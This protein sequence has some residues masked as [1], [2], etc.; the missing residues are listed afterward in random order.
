[1]DSTTDDWRPIP[2]YGGDYAISRAGGVRSNVFRPPIRVGEPLQQRSGYRG[3]W[4]VSLWNSATR[5]QK[6][7][8]VH[9]LMASIFIPGYDCRRDVVEHINGDRTDNRL[10][11]LRTVPRSAAARGESSAPPADGG[12]WKRI[13]DFP[14]YL[15]SDQGRVWR[16]IPALT[17]PAGEIR[18]Q[19]MHDYLTVV[20]AA[21]GRKKPFLVH[22]LVATLFLPPPTDAKATTVNHKDGDKS[23]NRVE[24]LEWMSP[25]QNNIHAIA[26]L[27]RRRS[28]TVEQAH[29]LCARYR[30]GE[31]QVDL[32]KAYGVYQ[33]EVSLIVRGRSWQTDGSVAAPLP[34]PVREPPPAMGSVVEEWR[35]PASRPEVEVSNLGRLRKTRM[36][37]IVPTQLTHGYPFARLRDASGVVK[38][39]CIHRLVAEC[40]LPPPADGETM[41]HHRNRCRDDNRAENL[42][43]MTSA[44]NQRHRRESACGDV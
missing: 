15:V 9:T 43:W 31:R 8:Q 6:S 33:Q 20:L 40:F 23:N 35:C 19:N 36:G 10:E 37:R 13:P 32:A 28:L 4:T 24:N 18:P 26:V 25:R 30:A 12:S 1:M 5:S 21:G 16:E 2:G 42:A 41:V 11:N 38:N 39:T 17:R 14:A 29:E 7:Y 3:C 44:H 34:V 27:K 22:R